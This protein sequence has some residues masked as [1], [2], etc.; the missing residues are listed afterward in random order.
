MIVPLDVE[1]EHLAGPAMNPETGA[2]TAAL[3]VVGIREQGEGR[4]LLLDAAGDVARSRRAKRVRKAAM[5]L[6]VSDST[7]FSWSSLVWSL[8]W[9]ERSW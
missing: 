2:G 9:C 4:P 8:P 1:A 3:A 6:R 7:I 5:S